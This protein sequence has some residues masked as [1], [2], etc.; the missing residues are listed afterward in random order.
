MKTDEEVLVKAASSFTGREGAIGNLQAEIPHW[1]FDQT[2]RELTGIWEKHLA[3]I[4]IKTDDETARRK[5]YGAM[6]RASFLPRTF[7]DADGR[8]PPLPRASLSAS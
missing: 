1:D 4:Q 7:N 5:F 6:Y 8:Y 3:S 2:R